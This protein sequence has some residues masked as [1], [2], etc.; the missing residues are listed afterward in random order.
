MRK[1]IESTIEDVSESKNF[2]INQINSAVDKKS[3]QILRVVTDI[4]SK[5]LS[6]FLVDEIVEEI[7]AAING[8]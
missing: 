4:L 7:I 5:K 3:K 2:K 1:K 6:K 8:K